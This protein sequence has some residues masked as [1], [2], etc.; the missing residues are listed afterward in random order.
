VSG[1]RRALITGITGQDGSYL[2]DLLLEKGYEVHGMVR[3]ASTETFQRLAHIRDDIVLHTGDLLDQ[4]SLVDVLRDSEPDEI[5][6]LAAMSFVA[7]SWSQ[8]TLTAEFT[9]VGVTRMLEA[10][11]EV[12]PQARFYQASSSEMF[13]KV[14]EVPQRESTPFYPRSPYGVAKV[15]GHFITVNYRESYDLFA[16][17]GILFNHECLHAQLPLIVRETGVLAV[18]TPPDLVPLRG[19]GPSIQT[20]EPGGLLEIWD[21]DDWTTV[22]GITATRRRTRDRDHRLISIQA[23]AGVVDA[24]AHHVMLD[25]EGDET[26]AD[27]FE[28]GD[29]VALCDEMPEPALWTVVSEEMAEFFGLMV[30]DGWVDRRGNHISFTNND[31]ELRRRVAALW[32]RLFLGTSHEWDGRS[33]FDPQVTVVKISLNGATG[34]RAF[35]RDQLYTKTAHKQVPPLVLNASSEIWEAFLKGYYAGD[36][37]KK[38]KGMS[39]KTNSPVL[40]QGLCWMYHWLDQPASVYVE[41]RAGRAYYTLNLASGVRVGAKGQ[42]LRKDPAEIRRICEPAEDSEWV[43]DLE[44][45]SGTFCAG[46]G[47]IMVHNSPRRGLEFVTRKVTHGAA[48]IKL[49]LQDELALGNLDAERDWG[50]AKDYVEAMWLMLQQDEPEDYVIATGEAHS[51]RELVQVAFEHVGLDPDKHV[52]ID[53][54]FLRPAEVEHLVGDY[55][56]AREKLGWQPRT[57]FEEMIRLMVDSDLELLSRGVPQKQAG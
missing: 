39:V 16:A 27:S 6:N 8:P 40:A 1:R 20:F 42:H 5:Y 24:T 57:S 11:R 31:P 44:T 50:Y 19:K 35:L 41:Q 45:E 23:R 2:A 26:R 46:I 17:S 12:V 18:K 10:M 36:G 37:L 21:G 30:A 49:G 4:R 48:A 38:G 55:S 29:R 34:S 9:A 33:G 25:A 15:Y 7:A 56:K 53:P 32:S 3:R 52:R 22:C 51:V 28:E 14:R 13:G 43:F 47:R 54:R